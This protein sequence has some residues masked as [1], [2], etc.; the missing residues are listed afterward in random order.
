MNGTS[1]VM[2]GLLR[3]TILALL[4]GMPAGGQSAGPQPSPGEPY[5]L[6]RITYHHPDLAVDLGVGL[7]G[8]PQPMDADG[9]GDLDMV[10]SCPD[11]PSS[12]VY[13][14]ENRQG[15]VKFPVFSRP[16]RIG[17]APRNLRPSYLK[18]KVVLLAPALEFPDVTS[19]S[20]GKSVKLPLPENVHDNTRIRANQWQYVDYDGNGVYDLVV[21]VGDWSDYGWDN[22]FDS[23]GHW[24]KGP[25]HG[26]VYLLANTGTNQAPAYAKPRK[27]EAAGKPIDVYGMPSPCFADF[28]GDGDLD[29]ICGDF[30][31][32]FTWFE[33]IGTRTAPQYATGRLLPSHGQ[34]LRMDLCML[35]VVA[36]D[37]DKDGD[38]DLVVGQEDGRVA[39]VE[40]TGKKTDGLPE[41]LPPRFFQQQAGD[42]KFG[43]L[44]TPAG[45]DWDGDGDDDLI[46]GDTAGHIGFLENLGGNPPRWAA[47]KCLEADGQVIHIQAG[48][49]GSIQGPCE[50]K[51][52]YT[53]P[54]VAD[55]DQ[56][57]LPD[58]LVN[59]I[60]GKILWFRNVGT[61]TAPRLA[62]AQPVEVQWTGKP[63][64]PAWTWWQPKDNE[65]VTQWRT[66]PVVIDWTGD[67]LADLVMLDTEGYLCLYERK[68]VD[69]QLQL[70]PPKRVFRDEKG[71]P[72][73]LNAKTAGGSGRRK[74]CMAD[75]DGDG[76]I[77]LLANSRNVEF[78]KN[79][80]TQNGITTLVNQGDV[81][82]RPLA[83]HSTCP[84]VVD[85]DRNGVPD[86]VVGAEDGCFYYM[87]NPHAPKAASSTQNSG[88]S[89]TQPGVLL[90]E[91]LYQKAPFPQCHASTIAQSGSTLVAA[92]F[93]GTAEG[94]PDVGIWVSRN[95]SDRWS[96]P[97]EVA[98]GISPDAKRYPC[99]NPVLFQVDSGPLLLF[100]K[101]GPS[102]A[103]WWGMLLRSVDGGRSWS[104]PEHLPNNI[105]GP[106]KN[107][108]VMLKDGRLLCG[109]STEHQGWT[110]H[111]EWTPDLGRTWQRTGPLNAPEQ[112]G[113]IQPTILVHPNQNLQILSRTRQGRISETWSDDGGH[114]WSPMRLTD[115]PNP[116]SGIDA[117]TL[118]D[119]RQ[120]LVYN[121]TGVPEGK[122]GGRRYPLNVAVSQD[123]KLW[124]AALV[125]ET[126]PGE[127][128]YPAVIQTRDGLVHATYTFNRT[129]I[130]H[131]VLDP[132]KLQL[133]ELPKL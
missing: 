116:N 67:G 113:A 109:S 62:A 110:D 43:A 132:N 130:K 38:V 53:A 128:S 22:A 59:T 36:I 81:D 90:T 45:C 72:L 70:M 20:L 114:S 78:W 75:W 8:A 5:K 77:D 73:Q 17:D 122:H 103:R 56:D 104:R 120:L 71:Q 102:P 88:D 82:S 15:N 24:T 18:D 65:L 32:T 58:I 87:T 79:M 13:F 86:L 7:W 108:P 6:Q 12:G 126:G 98:N 3:C 76:R 101:V 1:R 97:A 57:G 112:F 99:W 68:R 21:G 49:N 51:W 11:K 2:T 74:L 115:L 119:G 40:N 100:Y 34:P 69:G 16:V 25:L 46:C 23:Q 31:D 93:G 133:R 117:V 89:D 91:F 118:A 84:T 63:P 41:F 83:G 27:L 10:M 14:F 28:D 66:T 37:W 48:P 60:W 42:L 111:M 105:L 26:Y 121:H 124:K 50:A 52:G 92:W 106:I 94:K 33:N 9:D 64:K 4:T 44:S 123:G 129:R 80:G 55:W 131:V 19:Q 54:C 47:S 127:F 107:K 35:E 85:W 96:E 61:R 29:L 39:L 125:L 30:L 95:E